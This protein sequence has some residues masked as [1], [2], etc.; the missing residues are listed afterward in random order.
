MGF[1]DG[2]GLRQ[3]WN[4][5]KLRLGSKADKARVEAIEAEVDEIKSFLRPPETG[6][7]ILQSVDGVLQWVEVPTLLAVDKE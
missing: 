2:D 7:M 5:L 6:T 4:D 3:L 1:L